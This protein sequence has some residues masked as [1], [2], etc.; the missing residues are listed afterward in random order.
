MWMNVLCTDKPRVRNVVG[1]STCC[2]WSLRM[3]PEQSEPAAHA[4]AAL[5]LLPHVTCSHSSLQAVFM[6]SFMHCG[7]V[8]VEPS[9]FG[10]QCIFMELGEGVGR[11]CREHGV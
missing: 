8:L 7:R 5:P 3:R 1:V 6:S 9:S 10:K 11:N 2:F 4:A